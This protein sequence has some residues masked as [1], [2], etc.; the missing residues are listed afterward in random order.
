MI[1]ERAKEVALLVALSDGIVLCLAFVAALQLRSGLLARYYPSLHSLPAS[2]YLWLLPVSI[3]T[4]CILFWVAGLYDSLRTKPLLDFPLM[5]LKPVALGALFLGA[6]IF[7]V[8]A[9]Y[10]SRSLFGLF[11]GIFYVLTLAEKVAIRLAQ[12]HVR[13][14]GFNYR[15]V[16]IVGINEGALRIA[17]E[18]RE[19]RDFGFKVAG[20]LNGYGQDYVEADKYK[21]LGSIEDLSQIIDHHIIDEIIFALPLDQ[22][23]RCEAQILKCEEVG[24]KIHI[25]A[26]IAHSLF[27]RTYL[28][29][30]ADIPLLTL[31]TTPYSAGEVVLK[32]LLDVVVSLAGLV[33]LSPLVALISVLVKVE[34]RGP[35]Y[36]RQVRC[37]LNG[38]RFVLLKFRSMVHDAERQQKALEGLNEMTGPVFKMR[39]DPRI[40]RIGAFLRKTS[41]DELPQLWNVLRGDMS[42]VG[43]RPPLPSEVQKYERW[44]RRRLSMKPGITCLWQVSGRNAIDFEEW[45]KLDMQYIDNWSLGLDFKILAKTIPAVLSS[46]GAH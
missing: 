29:K 16:V 40:T 6:V 26:D 4:F 37:G 25:R 22:I 20:L 35:A 31:S 1:K 11:L 44:H 34:S 33:I 21:V 17:D 39:N 27:A 41:L 12:M 14:R 2:N 36:F 13:R 18:L 15:S 3:P 5:V 32:R 42:L 45:M 28:S 30:V 19:K 10:F 38:R 9:K 46:R 7:F 24:L 43:P 23:A 8:Q